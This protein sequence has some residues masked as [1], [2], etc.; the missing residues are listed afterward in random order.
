MKTVSVLAVVF[1]SML[2]ACERSQATAVE[3]TTGVTAAA[4]EARPGPVAKVVFVGK[5]RACDCT[6]KTVDAGWAALETV[7]GNPAKLPVEKLQIDT[8]ASR[9]APYRALRPLLM[10]L[11]GIYLLDAKGQLVELLQGEVSAE[12]IAAALGGTGPQAP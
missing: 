7:L 11:P 5:E 9:V 2:A 8:D 10:A 3:G 12:Q 6:R 1:C 4:A